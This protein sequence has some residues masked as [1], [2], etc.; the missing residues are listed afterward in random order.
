MVIMTYQYE[1]I[2]K[3]YP[4]QGKKVKGS[5]FGSSIMKYL[6]ETN[7]SHSDIKSR[8]QIQNHRTLY[9]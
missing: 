2:I 5:Y 9:L 4:K 1:I 3:Q 8:F 6:N 7:L